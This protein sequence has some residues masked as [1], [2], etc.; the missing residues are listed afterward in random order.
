M[1]CQGQG[2][3]DEGQKLE[4][5]LLV[6]VFKGIKWVCFGSIHLPFSL[7]MTFLIRLSF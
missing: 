4:V 3:D 2:Q 6:M 7:E 5:F 1:E